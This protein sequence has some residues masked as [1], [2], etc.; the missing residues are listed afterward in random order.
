MDD[1][2]IGSNDSADTSG[3]VPGWMATYG[4][5]MSLLLTFFILLATFSSIELVKFQKAMG[6]LQGA[7]GVLETDRGKNIQIADMT[8]YEK[9]KM[10]GSIYELQSLIFEN[11]LEESV[12]MEISDGLRIR[13]NDKVM[14]DLGGEALKPEILPFMRRVAE[15]LKRIPAEIRVEGHTDDLPINSVKFSSNWD[16]SAARALSTLKFLVYACGVQPEKF[17]AVGYGQ[18]RPRLP[19]TDMLNRAKNRRVEIFVKLPDELL[20]SARKSRKTK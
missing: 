5:M 2:E 10:I 15:V 3:M 20:G 9:E 14:F 4:D 12:E 6:S 13:I 1:L 18:Y 7:L 17:S 8:A 16:L 19:N 11:G